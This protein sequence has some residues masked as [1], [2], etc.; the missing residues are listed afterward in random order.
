MKMPKQ[1]FLD[2]SYHMFESRWDIGCR[3]YISERLTVH[4]L[5]NK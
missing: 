5:S 3:V 2:H 1:F 4:N